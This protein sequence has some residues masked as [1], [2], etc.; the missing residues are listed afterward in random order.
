MDIEIG[1][2]VGLHPITYAK[3]HP[4]RNLVALEH[5]KEKFDKFW[6]R[7]ENHASLDNLYPI[8]GNAISWISAHIK[9]ASVS[10][11]FLLYPNPWPKARHK[12][13]RWAAMPFMAKLHETL[14]VGVNC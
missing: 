14:A 4:D 1:C 2:G 10:R 6:G 8:H 9:P 5:T 12:N 7:Y 3:I 13:R 11:Y